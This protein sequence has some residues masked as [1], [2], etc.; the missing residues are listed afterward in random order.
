[1]EEHYWMNSFKKLCSLLPHSTNHFTDLIWVVVYEPF[2]PPIGASLPTLQNKIKHKA[3][4]TVIHLLSTS[5]DQQN[6]FSFFG[7]EWLYVSG[8]K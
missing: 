5:R 1:M 2:E 7:C 6:F 4:K 3:M 8:S